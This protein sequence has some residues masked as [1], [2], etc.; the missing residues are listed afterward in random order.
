MQRFCKTEEVCYHE[1][2]RRP[3][4]KVEKEFAALSK[5]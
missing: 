1:G 5:E 3:F 2:Y 4:L